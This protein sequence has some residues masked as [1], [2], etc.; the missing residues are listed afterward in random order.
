MVSNHVQ[1][2]IDRYGTDGS[3]IP[4]ALTDYVEARKFYDYNEHSRVGAK[5]G[6]FVTDEICDRFCVARQRRAGDREAEG[7]RVDRRRPVQHLPDDA[8]PGGDARGVRP[9]HPAAVRGSGGVEASTESPAALGRRGRR[10]GGRARARSRPS[11]RPSRR[12]SSRR[13]HPQPGDIVLELAGGTGELAEALAGRVAQRDLRPT[14]R[15]RWSRRRARRGIAGRRAPRA[16]T[17]RRSTSRTRASTG[18]SRRFGYMLV[19]DPAL[20]AARDA[21]RAPRRA[22]RLA[23]ATWAPAKRNP[24]ATAYGPVLIERGLLEPPQPGEPGQFALGEPERIEE[25]VRARRLRARSTVEEVAGRVPASQTGTTTARVVTVARRLA[26]R[27]A[28]GARRRRLGPRWTTA[29]RAR[30]E[31]FRDRRAATSSR[32][33]RS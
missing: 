11:T 24:W 6:E 5:H 29:A 7:A 2:L 3:T 27:D 10:L 8:G 15:R 9:R 25:L 17:C 30:L 16:W 14:S 1:D 22:G 33:S 12:R 32:A 20:R 31:P 26:A 18:S 28:R 21:S 23:F 4:K 13:S 19:P